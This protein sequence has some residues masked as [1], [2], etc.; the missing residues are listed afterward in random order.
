MMALIIPAALLLG[1]AFQTSVAHRL[2]V[3]GAKPD[4]LL[5]MVSVLALTRGR[6]YAVATGLAAG[7]LQDLVVGRMIGS[8]ALAKGVCGYLVGSMEPNLYKENPIVPF[9]VVFLTTVVNEALYGFL[10]AS[11]DPSFAPGASTLGQLVLGA[12]Y[13]GLL[14]VLFYRWLTKIDASVG[15]QQRGGYMGRSV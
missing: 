12:V 1:V 11:F 9:L 6:S 3:M 4:I 14:G 5:V 15:R 2:A 8:S 7:M 10:A 13:N